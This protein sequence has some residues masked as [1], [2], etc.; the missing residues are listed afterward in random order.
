MDE[1]AA[2]V[3]GTIAAVEAV[4]ALA[5]ADAETLRFALR[6]ALCSSKE[7]WDLFDRLFDARPSP[8]S[9]PPRGGLWVPA[10]VAAAGTAQRQTGEGKMTV[11][12]G[13]HEHL[14][15]TD[16]SQV[17]A[18]H[19]QELERMA[20]RLLRR[21]SF[22]LSRRLKLSERRGRVDLRRTIRRSVS[23]GGD[24]LDLRYRNRKKRQARLVLL[25][26]VSGSMN[27]YSLFLLRFAHALHQ[28]FSSA[29]TFLFSTGLV[30]ITSTLRSR[31]LAGALRA[32][33]EV[34]AGWSGGTKIGESLRDFDRR[35]GR[36]SLRR[37]TLLMVMSDGWDTGEPEV[38]AAELRA[39]KGR[40]RK[41]VWLNPL[42]GLQEYRP[43]TRGMAAALPYIDV[44]APA[45]TLESLLDLER[46]LCSTSS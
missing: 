29:E 33:A 40:V 35:Y 44:F 31:P 8:R 3:N 34:P 1:F 23:R 22:R 27:L 30:N 15:K 4:R 17:P 24:P 12:A 32:V 21:L 20:Q 45:H 14:R 25:L 41:I 37:D 26:D 46:H 10:G 6:A 28:H 16:F 42:L 13:L 36:H 38:L 19:Q 39:I 5:G 7:E 18:G 2:G 43:V 9:G 11:G